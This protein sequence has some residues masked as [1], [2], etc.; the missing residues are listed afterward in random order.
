MSEYL[1]KNNKFQIMMELSE[2]VSYMKLLHE[3]KGDFPNMADDFIH[4]CIKQV[5]QFFESKF[6]GIFS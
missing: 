1:N 5:S 2:N 3:L 4:Q 6:D